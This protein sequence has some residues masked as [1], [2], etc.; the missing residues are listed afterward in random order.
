MKL[1]RSN[2]QGSLISLFSG[3][4]LLD[5]WQCRKRVLL[6][7]LQVIATLVSEVLSRW[8]EIYEYQSRDFLYLS[9][10]VDKWFLDAKPVINIAFGN[11]RWYGAE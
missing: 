9:A 4:Y 11:V 6:K 5:A 10:P 1:Q 7:V 2:E 8:L 3:K